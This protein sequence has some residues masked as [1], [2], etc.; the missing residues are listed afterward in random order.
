[1]HILEKKIRHQ[2]SSN[3]GLLMKMLNFYRLARQSF[4]LGH[5]LSE[6]I[7]N[8]LGCFVST[9]DYLRGSTR[10]ARTAQAKKRSNIYILVGTSLGQTMGDFS[11]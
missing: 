5:F 11:L 2:K 4:A 8:S 9:A 1:M 10:L 3:L 6:P 7:K